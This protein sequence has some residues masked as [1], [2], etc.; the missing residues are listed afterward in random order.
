MERSDWEYVAYVSADGYHVGFLMSGGG[1]GANAQFYG[2]TLRNCETAV[3]VEQTNPFGMEFAKCTFEG[4]KYGFH[5]G[6]RFSAGIMLNDC[7]VAADQALYSEGTGCFITQNSRIK[8]GNITVDGG[9]LTMT[10]SK[11]ED[12]AT[13]ITLGKNV[14]GA[15]LVGNTFA[16]NPPAIKSELPADKLFRER[17]AGDAGALPRV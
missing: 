5:L 11:I 1:G 16:K 4:L 7:D 9:V 3:E 2:M 15:S 6:A 12:A 13:Q 8:H 17:Q 14:R 10:A